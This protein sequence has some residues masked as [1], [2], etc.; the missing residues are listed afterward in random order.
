MKNKESRDQKNSETKK[1]Y[2]F[3]A[4]NTNSGSGNGDQSG[5][6]FGWSFKKD[7]YLNWEGQ[8]SQSSNTPAIDSN[9][10]LAKKDKK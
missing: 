1:N 2:Q 6:A 10:T 3:F 9:V 7:Y 8:Q 4:T 5:Q